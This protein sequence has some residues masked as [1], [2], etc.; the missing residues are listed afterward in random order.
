M[1]EVIVR[2]DESGDNGSD[3]EAVRGSVVRSDDGRA[4]IRFA[5]WLQLL[6][7]L[8]DLTMGGDDG[9]EPPRP[10]GSVGPRLAPEGL[11]GTEGS[12]T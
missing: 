2:F 12:P 1:V 7:L 6:S 5:G 3:G 9:T 10:L 4:P 11:R 8:E